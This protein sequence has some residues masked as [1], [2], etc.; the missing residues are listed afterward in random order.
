MVASTAIHKLSQNSC[1]GIFSR[2]R[3]RLPVARHVSRNL[4]RGS[5]KLVYDLHRCLWIGENI[6]LGGDGEID[7]ILGF[8]YDGDQVVLQFEREVT[9][10]GLTTGSPLP[11][12]EGQGE[13]VLSMADLGHRY[14]WQPNAVD[15]LM[16]DEAL[17]PLPVGEGQ[18]EGGYDLSQPGTVVLPLSDQQGTI[19]DLA[20]YDDGTGKTSIVAHRVYD[21]FGNL[22]SQTSAVDCLFAYTGRAFDRATGLQNNLN[23][24]YDAK[25][26]RWASEDPIGFNGKDTNV[27]RYVGNSPTNATDPRGLVPLRICVAI[28]D[29]EDKGSE[30]WNPSVPNKGPD[31]VATAVGFERGAKLAAGENVIAVGGDSALEQAV[32]KLKQLMAGGQHIGV[33]VICDHNDWLGEPGKQKRAQGLG[34]KAI[35]PTDPLWIE[36][37]SLVDVG[38]VIVF[39]GCAVADTDI[40]ILKQ[41]AKNAGRRVRACLKKTHNDWVPGGWIDVY[42]NGHIDYGVN[43]LAP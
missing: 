24:W 5:G 14:L 21:A 7:R 6:D 33:L 43:P 27:S 2:H 25:V 34:N 28:Y 39:G 17:S 42:P 11:M 10:E 22:K 13:G 23:R 9:G 18:G 40:A 31:G 41:Y 20:V 38:G 12:G 32:I 8:V 36:L 4:R 15:Q 16:A 30:D 3:Q 37:T 29:A 26:G 19:K 35:S 1:R